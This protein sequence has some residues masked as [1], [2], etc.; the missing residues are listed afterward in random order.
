MGA[1]EDEEGGGTGCQTPFTLL[2]PAP[3]PPQFM[4]VAFVN[5]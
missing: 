2:F 4:H 3:A 1:Q 5:H